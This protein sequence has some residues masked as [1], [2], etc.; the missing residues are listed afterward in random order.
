MNAGKLETG[1]TALTP[2]GQLLQSPDGVALFTANKNFAQF[3]ESKG[4]ACKGLKKH[5][6]L[7][8]SFLRLFLKYL[9]RN[10]E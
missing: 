6:K 9:E 3:L 4:V 2:D 10:V 1:L 5:V 7:F 8:C